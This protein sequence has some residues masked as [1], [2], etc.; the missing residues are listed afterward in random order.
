MTRRSVFGNPIE[1]EAILQKPEAEEFESDRLTRTEEG[2]KIS[3]GEKEMVFGL[4]ENVRGINK[5]GHIY[6]SFCSDNPNHDEST[7]SLYGGHNFFILSDS[8]LGVFIDCPFEVTF[9]I[10]YT[11]ISELSIKLER[12]DFELYLI[13]GESCDAVVKEFRGLIGMS[14]IPPIWAFGYGQCRWSYMSEEEVREVADR[15]KENGLPLDMIYLDIDYMDGYRDFTINRKS[16]PNFEKLVEDMKARNV[17]LIPIIDAGIKKDEGFDTYDEGREK[18]YF[19]K[20][21]N[22]DDFVV[23]VWPGKCCFP[24]ML[25]DEAREWFGNKYKFLLDKGIDGF[26]NDM[27]EPAIFYSEKRLNRTFEKI[28]AYQ[29]ENLDIDSFFRVKDI[30]NNISNSDEDYASFYHNY[31]GEK[32]CHKDVHN[33]F[34]YYMTR[35]ASEAFE[36]LAPDKQILMFSRAS[37]IG[38]HRYGGIWQGDNKSWWSHLLMNIKMMPSLN[39]CGF[40]Y[41]GADLGGFGCDT[42]ED[43][44]LRWLAFG[45]FTP[46]M[47]NHSAAGTRRQEPYRF[48]NIKAFRNVMGV[49]YKMLPYIYSEYMKAA[50]RGTMMFRPLA[51]EYCNDDVIC[52]VEDQL[53][54]GDS[55]MIAPVYEQNAIGRTVYIP[56][57]MQLIRFKNGEV[58][59]EKIYDK[60]VIYI[61]VAL[62]EVVIFLRENH[63]LPLSE[64]GMSVP[65]TDMEHLTFLSFGVDVKAYE[66]Y[67]EEGIKEI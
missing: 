34:G 6:K 51:F 36:R 12:Q 2:F 54:L 40:L 38:M 13:E 43:L 61:D 32:V 37:Y 47:R 59:R 56:E 3:L 17:H 7:T 8:K 19:C 4:G 16:F 44:V 42:T 26:W 53:L 23:G 60:G 41:T 21:E 25:N 52:H 48:S 10:G 27:N 58:I 9:D 39:M 50:L 64:G 33:L 22:G 14:Y 62:D 35:G 63:V 31:K 67:T 11:E 55:I 24:D 46:L 30:F 5:R 57:R 65:E 15:F 20:D 66:Y 28:K 49:R 29:N 18:G 45:V 1:T